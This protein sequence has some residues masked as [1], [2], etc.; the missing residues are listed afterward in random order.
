MSTLITGGTGLVGRELLRRLEAPVLVSRDAAKASRDAGCPAISWEALQKSPE[1]SLRGVSAIVHLAG[2][3]LAEGRWTESR[4]KLFRTSRIDTAKVLVDALAHTAATSRPATLVSASAV[5][6][7]GDRGDELL[8]EESA[9][10]SGFLAD[11]CRDWEAA[12][13]RARGL[14]VRVVNP[15]IGVVLSPSGGALAKMLPPFR[16]GVGGPLA[17]GKAWMPWIH[18]HD[19][20]EMIAWAIRNP[21]V[22]GPLNVA[23]PHSATNGEFTSALGQALHRPA[24]FP[25]PGLAVRALFGEMATAVLASTRMIPAK[26]QALGFS[27]KF[28]TLAGALADVLG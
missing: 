20:A 17:G 26:A 23:A 11:L 7:Y 24:V 28:P 15:R 13:H 12:A 22:E 8:T 19:A 9:I 27:F 1:A 3:P 2:E 25:V 16:L 21:S 18:L 4:K 10:G 14:G 5:G 6:I